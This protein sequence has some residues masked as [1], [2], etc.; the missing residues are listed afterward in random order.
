VDELIAPN[1]VQHFPQSH[2]PVKG[3]EGYKQLVRHYLNAFPD[4]HFTIDEVVSDGQTVVIRGSFT[5]THTG[6]LPGLPAT[7]RSTGV[8][9]M[10]CGHVENGK[11]AETWSNWDT[12]GLRQQLGVI[13]SQPVQQAA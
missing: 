10:V 6:D 4:L 9:G 2:F 7:G 8:T 12:L 11:F 1:F 3:V 5:A 13:P